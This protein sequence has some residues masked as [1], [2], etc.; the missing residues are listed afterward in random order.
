MKV[1]VKQAARRRGKADRSHGAIEQAARRF[2][3]R[4]AADPHLSR[5]RAPGAPISTRSACRSS[6]AARRPD[7]RMAR[8]RR[9]S[10]RQRGLCRRRARPRM[11]HGRASSYEIAAR[12][13]LRPRRPRIHAHR[14][15][16][17]TALPAGPYRRPRQDHPVHAR[18]QEG[19]PAGGDPRRGIREVPRQEIRRHQA[20][21]P[22]RRRIDDPRAG[23]GDQ[24]RR[25]A[26]R[27]RDH[28]RHGPP[29]PA[30]RARERD[31][32]ALQ[33]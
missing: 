7:A 32:Q 22:R 10:A 12:Q 14:R 29:R 21:R 17:G 16:R 4:H 26:G 18:R 9:R 28:L 19:D 23:S 24:V 15:Y 1:A 11:G 3:P 31:G 2:D 20:L 30:E 33:A 8:L 27:A 25:R 5:A 6:E 13:L